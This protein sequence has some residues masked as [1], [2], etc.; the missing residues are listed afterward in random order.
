MARIILPFIFCFAIPAIIFAQPSLSLPS[1]FG[2]HMVLQRGQVNPVWGWSNPGDLVIVKIDGQSHQARADADGKWKVYLQPLLVGGPYEMTIAGANTQFKIRDILVGEVWICSGQSNMAW[3]IERTNHADLEIASANH[4]NIRVIS[5]PQVGTQEPKNDFDGSWQK[6][7]PQSVRDFSAVG[8]FFGR[9]L[10][11]TLDVPIGLIDNAWGGSSAE[12]WIPREVL[13]KAGRYSELMASWE[14]REA[15]YDYEQLLGDWEQKLQAWKDE[16]RQGNA[17]FKPRNLMAGNH[18]PANIYN[19]VLHP[20]IGYGIRGVIWY[21][22]E[23]N[24][25]RAYQYR[26]LFP[27]MIETWRKVWKQGDFPFYYVQLADFKAEEENPAES[28]WA[29]LR[30]AQTQTMD[31]LGNVGEAVIIDVGEGRDIHPRDKQTVANRLA[32]WALARDYGIRMD[33]Q[34][35][36]Y[37]S[38]EITGGKIILT[39]NHVG[40]TLYTFDTNKPMGFAVAGANKE[41]VWAEAEIIDENRIQVWS[42]QIANPVAVRYAWANNPICN[43]YSREGLPLTPFRTD[44]WHGVTKGVEK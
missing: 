25:G 18:R 29:E 14:E 41:F 30:E 38:M 26:D 3:P 12:A 1:I 2:D 16:G 33:H 5:V 10:L 23:S 34:S 24:A 7:T 44:T 32:R 37:R 9:R 35:P 13:N 22:G 39:F 27:L 21:Q 40:S 17:P 6:C 28:D 19:G 15:G 36:R 42:D 20:T 11:N 43:V 4:P 8:Y 31:R